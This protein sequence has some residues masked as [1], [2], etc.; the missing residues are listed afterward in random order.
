MTPILIDFWDLHLEIMVL[1]M[2]MD[3]ET[4]NL[5]HFICECVVSVNCHEGWQA[6]LVKAGWS[7]LVQNWS[8]LTWLQVVQVPGITIACHILPHR[9]APSMNPSLLGSLKRWMRMNWPLAPLLKFSMP[10]G[11][12]SAGMF[13]VCFFFLD[14]YVSRSCSFKLD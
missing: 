5:Y 9:L 2:H 4:S 13:T 12:L 11:I 14:L 3:R 1:K 8:Q 7:H 6:F 10:S